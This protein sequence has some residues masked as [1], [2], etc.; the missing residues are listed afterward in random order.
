MSYQ[1]AETGFGVF[2]VDDRDQAISQ[3]LICTGDF[4][5]NQ[6]ALV[7][8]FLKNFSRLIFQEKAAEGKKPHG[9]SNLEE[10][11]AL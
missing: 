3:S 4:E 11:S 1:I 9:S 5:T 2:V 8:E 6:I 10:P 7:L